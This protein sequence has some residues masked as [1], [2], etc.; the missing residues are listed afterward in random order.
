[1]RYVKIKAKNYNEAMMKLKMEYGDEAIPISHKYIKEGG[2]LHS[3]FFAKD[4]VELTA[5]IQEKKRMT[6]PRNERKSTLDV[7]VDEEFTSKVVGS[8]IINNVEDENV[9]ERIASMRSLNQTAKSG[10]KQDDSARGGSTAGSG[11][12][13]IRQEELESL[14]RIEREFHD[15]KEKLN[16]MMEDRGRE[17]HREELDEHEEPN[18][19]SCFDVLVRNEFDREECLSLIS[20]VKN[21][22]SREDLKDRFKIEKTMKDLLKSRIVTSGPIRPEGKKKVIMFF[23][24]TGVGKT[25]TM[26]K[27]GAIFALREGYRVS[28]VSIDNYRIAATEQLKKYAE[29]IKIPILSSILSI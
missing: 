10:V 3:R 9:Q 25:T 20:R 2:I 14:K 13:Q 24:P 16:Q 5:A 4:V 7:T 8:R 6:M 26:A 22:M 17:Q 18:V 28:F 1:M 11:T 12:V 23:G 29:I 19:K 15:I 21:A 27:L